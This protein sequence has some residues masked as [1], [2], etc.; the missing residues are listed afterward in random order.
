MA[1]S[2]L[3]QRTYFKCILNDLKE[4]FVY[5]GQTKER[6]KD[7]S[8]MLPM[9]AVLRMP[10]KDKPGLIHLVPLEIYEKEIFNDSKRLSA[11]MLQRVPD[12]DWEYLAIARHHGLPARYLD[13]SENPLVALYFSVYIKETKWESIRKKYA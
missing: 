13:W 11:S 7:G 8:L 6:N 2:E 12:S 5:R 9:P 10:K 1:R 4:K 3:V